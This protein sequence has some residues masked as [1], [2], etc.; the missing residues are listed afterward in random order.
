MRQIYRVAGAAVAIASVI[1]V[2]RSIG[3]SYEHLPEAIFTVGFA[4]LMI[5][6]AVAYGGVNQLL[7]TAWYSLLTGF[8]RGTLTI[9]GALSIFNRTQIYKYLPGNVFHMV[10]RYS[11]AKKA[12]VEHLS[13]SMAQLGELALVCGAAVLVAGVSSLD[14]L[15]GVMKKYGLY[16]PL[17][18]GAALIA[19]VVAAVVG[20][21]LLPSRLFGAGVMK[22]TVL[23]LALYILFVLSNSFVAVIVALWVGAGGA[24][25]V[26]I[27]SVASTAWLFGFVIPGAPGGLGAREAVTIAGL[28]ALG[29][30]VPNATAI[31]ISHRLVT[32]AGDSIA[33]LLFLVWRPSHV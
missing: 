13:L 31:A 32:L 17:Y 7:G 15:T 33:F 10:G 21:K 23:S 18:I 6:L 19:A 8:G 27:I 22:S 20:L 26:Q 4:A 16:D 28:T 11:M 2:A 24:T 29:V 30:P 1:F 5:V 25:I 9:S 3:R 12:G 14:I